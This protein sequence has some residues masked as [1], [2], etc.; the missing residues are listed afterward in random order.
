[1]EIDFD[2]IKVIAFDADD[3]LWVNE[4]YFREVEH[5]V[6]KLL[7]AYETENKINQE[8]YRIEIKNLGHYGYGVKAFILSMVELA[9]EISNYKVP[10]KIINEIL[11][12][13]KEMLLK[14]IELLDGAEE[15][16][17]ALQGKYKLIV[18][19]K[20]DLLD[21][22]RKL[23]KS[24]LLNYFHHVEVMSDKKESD[25]LKIVKHL[26]IKPEELLMI[27]N[28]LKSDILPL[29]K[30]G[31]SAIHIP[32]HT[33]WLHEQVDEINYAKE[34]YKTFNHIQELLTTISIT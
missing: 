17:Q 21:Q 2:K 25:Y 32:Y 33:T 18:A 14:P 13:G 10:A 16:L 7:S 24:G 31:A 11:N 20:G 19:T 26:D 5:E 29:V 6:A 9:V 27:G 8:L 22:E 12:L 34:T 30:I 28:S 23:E 1:M 4:P 3:T 15:V